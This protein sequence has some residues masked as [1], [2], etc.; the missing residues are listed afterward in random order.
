MGE[1]HHERNP[2]KIGIITPVYNEA[3]SLPLYERR[4]RDILVDSREYNFHILLVDDGST[5]GSWRII[6]EVCRRDGTSQGIRLSP[7]FGSHRALTAGLFHIDG[8]AVATL[9]C[10]LQD[11]PEMILDFMRS[12]KA[13]AK[14]V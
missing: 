8:D 2:K 11:P 5:D 1:S 6:E 9:A 13:G 4:V 12:W 10:D 3:E 7:N 14:I